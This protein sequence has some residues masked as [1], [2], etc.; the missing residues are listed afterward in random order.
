MGKEKRPCEP[1][2]GR[3]GTKPGGK[4]GL[5]ISRNRRTGGAIKQE[6]TEPDWKKQ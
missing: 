1:N 4:N 6:G 5:G 2:P 3:A